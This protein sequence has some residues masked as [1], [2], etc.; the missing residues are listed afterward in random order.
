MSKPILTALALTLG[1]I[2]VTAQESGPPPVLSIGREEIKPGR[3][4]A[5]EKANASFVS[6]AGRAG[7]PGYWLGLVPVTG[8]DNATIFISAYSSFEEAEMERKQN[9]QATDAA[10]PAVKA[11]LE[12]INRQTG[13]MHASQRTMLARHRA[14]LS[15]R[16]RGMA[17]TA[18]ARYFSIATIRI[19]PGRVPD[20]ADYLRQLNAAREKAAIDVHA[21]VYQV[22]SGAQA[23][24]FL[25]FTSYR[26]LKEMDDNFAKDAERQKAIDEALGGAVVVER[27]RQLISEIVADNVSALFAMNP[28]IS[29]PAPQFAAAD[30]DFWSPKPATAKALAV[31]KEEKPKP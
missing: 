11:E 17:E 8:D 15:Y 6:L 12:A 14:D 10:T 25:V 7:L 20:Y 30:P 16:P 5:H 3:M 1:A 22:T 2:A 23:G 31:K 19:K 9:E 4:S 29:R 13:E 18:K 21:A 28:K 26:S 24:T 27:R